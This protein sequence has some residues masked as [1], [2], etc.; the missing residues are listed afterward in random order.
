M[1]QESLR[2]IAPDMGVELR[3]AT[4]RTYPGSPGLDI[5]TWDDGIG[6][7]WIM[8]DSMGVVGIIRAQTWEDA[9]SCAVDELL[10]DGEMPP[11]QFEDAHEEACWEEANSWRGG[12]PCNPRLELP[13]ASHDL[14]G[15]VLDALTPAFMRELGISI[16]LKRV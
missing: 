15:E 10:P 5:A 3:S 8:R 13:V 7:L 11:E 2:Q 9:F 14:N 12:T 1:K 16:E 6:P 4:L